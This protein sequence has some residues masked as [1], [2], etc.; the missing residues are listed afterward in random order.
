[1]TKQTFPPREGDLG[2]AELMD[3]A[4]Q[5]AALYEDQYEVTAYFKFTCEACGERVAFSEPNK[6]FRRGECHACGHETRV[7]RGGFLLHMQVRE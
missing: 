2:R 3:A 4:I 6:L 7:E 5:A 1:M